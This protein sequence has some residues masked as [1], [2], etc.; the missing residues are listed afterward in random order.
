MNSNEKRPKKPERP[1]ADE[2]KT[3]TRIVIGIFVVG[4]AAIYARFAGWIS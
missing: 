4:I 2:L 3:E 1:N